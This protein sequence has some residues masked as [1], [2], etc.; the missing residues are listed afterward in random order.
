MQYK[1]YYL[2]KKRN[3]P[4]ATLNIVHTSH[5]ISIASFAILMLVYT[6]SFA[7]KKDR[8][9]YRMYFLILLVKAI[10]HD[11]EFLIELLHLMGKY[12]KT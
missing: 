2:V 3:A 10:S 9:R 7:E 5:K 12:Q 8:K 11:R 4:N 6:F 1:E